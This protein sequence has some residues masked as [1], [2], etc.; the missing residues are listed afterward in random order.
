LP[1]D[2]SLSRASWRRASAIRRR[3]HARRSRPFGSPELRANDGARTLEIDAL[4][5]HHEDGARLLARDGKTRKQGGIDGYRRAAVDP[6][7]L[8]DAGDQKQQRYPRIGNDVSQRVDPV[9]AAPVGQQKGLRIF[10]GHEAGGIA[11]RADVETPG[12]GTCQRHEGGC[13][14]EGAIVRAEMVDLL[15]ERPRHGRPVERLERGDIRDFMGRI[16]SGFHSRRARA[17]IAAWARMWNRFS[18]S[19]AAICSRE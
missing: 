14:D 5:L 10:D 12:A 9:V 3:R 18:E 15:V 16:H 2:R 8:A 1:L 4:D 6:Q 13:L 19:T 11:A 17:A 7:R